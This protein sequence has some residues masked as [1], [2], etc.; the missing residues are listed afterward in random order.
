MF[1]GR[2]KEKRKEEGKERRKQGSRDGNQP[3]GHG[4]GGKGQGQEE[5]DLLKIWSNQEIEASP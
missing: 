1:L 4:L 2:R 3:E 5:S